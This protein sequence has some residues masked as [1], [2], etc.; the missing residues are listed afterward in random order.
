MGLCYQIKG[1]NRG[2]AKY[3]TNDIIKACE[4][5]EQNT[6][7]TKISKLTNISKRTIRHLIRN[8][9][10]THI[11]KDYDFTNYRCGKPADYNDRIEKVCQLLE[12]N[13][14]TMKEISRDTG[15]TYAMVKNILNGKAHTQISKKY[16]ISNFNK[17]ETNNKNR[18]KV[19]RLSKG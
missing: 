19:Q 15:I 3:S 11:T 10:W 14:L 9:G 2:N 5:V 18:V 4:L 1:E 7:I 8:E 17:Y 13:E 12:L 6:P 16:E